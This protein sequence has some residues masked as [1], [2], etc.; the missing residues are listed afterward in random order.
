M[1]RL[2]QSPTTSLQQISTS[3][4]FHSYLPN[5]YSGAKVEVAV[6]GA[7]VVEEEVHL[8]PQGASRHHL[9]NRHPLENLHPPAN[10]LAPAAPIQRLVQYQQAKRQ[11][12]RTLIRLRG[13][14]PQD[15]PLQVEQRGV[16]AEH[17]FMEQGQWHRFFKKKIFL[18]D[19]L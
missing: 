2:K 5:H 18:A 4:T 9:E 8:H 15:N 19:I 12:E 13:K 14:S 1:R 17:K 11:Q 3:C 16:R 6:A 10:L 7:E